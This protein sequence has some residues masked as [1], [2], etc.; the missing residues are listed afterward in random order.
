MSSD[1]RIEMNKRQ[2]EKNSQNRPAAAE[3]SG[4]QS[5]ERS[6]A[7]PPAS[8]S[9]KTNLAPNWINRGSLAPHVVPKPG[10]L[11]EVSNRVPKWCQFQRLKMS[12]R[13]WNR[14]SSLM[15]KVLVI[16]RS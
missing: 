6:P 11:I 8:Q 2:T 12:A 4:C 13:S 5:G 16:V 1:L 3:V 15:S 14:I 9:Q 7:T 10:L